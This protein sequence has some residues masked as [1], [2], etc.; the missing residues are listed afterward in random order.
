MAGILAQPQS[1]EPQSLEPQSPQPQSPLS[2]SQER[3]PTH[4]LPSTSR[5]GSEENRSWKK[6]TQPTS[7]AIRPSNSGRT[8]ANPSRKQPSC[9]KKRILPSRNSRHGALARNLTIPNQTTNVLLK[10]S[11]KAAMWPTAWIASCL[12]LSLAMTSKASAK[13]P[14]TRRRL[15][16]SSAPRPFARSVERPSSSNP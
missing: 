10:R 6:Y 5:C 4:A 3:L 16:V 11:G 13:M 2:R 15:Q 7:W 14:C 9:S 1:P 12:L 8:K